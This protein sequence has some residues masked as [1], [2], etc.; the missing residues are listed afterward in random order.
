MQFVVFVKRLSCMGFSKMQFSVK[1]NTYIYL[2][3]LLLAI[4]VRWVCSWVVAVA[5][6]EFCH[7]L[8]VKLCK[9]NVFSLEIGLNG[10]DMQCS[11]MT[12]RCRLFSVLCGPLVAFCW[13][14]LAVGFPDWRCVAAFMDYII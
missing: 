12:D 10:A 14:A 5:C 11:N 1:V 3:I 7:W 9:G 6:H 4:P 2:A 13:L 8:A